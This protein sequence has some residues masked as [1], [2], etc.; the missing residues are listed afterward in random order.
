MTVVYF[1]GGVTFAEISA[2]RYLGTLDE[3]RQYVVATTKIIH[4]DSLL[5]SMVEDI[6]PPDS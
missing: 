6:S 4:G 1:L 2:L 3:E 5:Q